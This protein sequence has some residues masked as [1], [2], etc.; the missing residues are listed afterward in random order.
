MNTL[1][2]TNA[3][4]CNIMCKKTLATLDI[5]YVRKFGI[6]TQCKACRMLFSC[7]Y[8]RFYGIIFGVLRPILVVSTTF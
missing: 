3:K 8:L 4:T 5:H 1:L 7:F 2:L 6:S